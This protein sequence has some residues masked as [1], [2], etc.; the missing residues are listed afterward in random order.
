M[1]REEF[2]VSVENLMQVEHTLEHA[3]GETVGFDIREMNVQ[4]Y[5]DNSLYIGTP[6]AFIFPDEIESFD[7]YF[8][9]VV[10]AHVVSIIEYEAAEDK[11]N[12][13][14]EYVKEKIRMPVEYY[15]VSDCQLPHVHIRLKDTQIILVDIE[16]NNHQQVSITF[17]FH[18][19]GWHDNLESWFGEYKV[20]RD[21]YVYE[22]E[23][24]KLVSDAEALQHMLQS[25]LT[26]TF[27]RNIA[28]YKH[29]EPKPTPPFYQKFF[30]TER[31]TFVEF[32]TA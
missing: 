11:L 26:T 17:G 21:I 32:F 15:A 31:R 5:P 23:C 22:V 12:S 29:A 8:Q 24:N 25:H 3:D 27:V 2:I 19:T 30:E 9:R 10:D 16:A 13:A 28:I 18:D 14:M 4:L 1:T 20:A 7:A 6:G